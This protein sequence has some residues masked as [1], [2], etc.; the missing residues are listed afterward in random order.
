MQQSSHEYDRVME[1]SYMR[2]CCGVPVVCQDGAD[3]VMRTCMYG[4]FGMSETAVGM[5][6]GV[7]EWVKQSTLRWYENVTRMNACNFTKRVYESTIEGMGVRGRP[8]VK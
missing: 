4:R 3:R 6:C 1:M 8:P 2:P 5:D 7:V